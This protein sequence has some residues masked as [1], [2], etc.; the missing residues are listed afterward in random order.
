MG[1]ANTRSS[2]EPVRY[3][4]ANSMSINL[5]VFGAFMKIMIVDKEDCISVIII[6]GHVT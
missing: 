2:D 5:G 6:H 1:R 3:S 4:V